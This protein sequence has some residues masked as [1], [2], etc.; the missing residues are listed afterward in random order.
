M[1][2]KKKVIE[3]ALLV[4]NAL[5]SVLKSIVKFIDYLGKTRKAPKECCGC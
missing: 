4:V 1:V 5:T 3:I 2:F